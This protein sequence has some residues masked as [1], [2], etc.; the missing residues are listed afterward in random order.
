M[1][2]LKNIKHVTINTYYLL[3][4]MNSPL[5]LKIK[6]LLFIV[7]AINSINLTSAREQIKKRFIFNYAL[8]M[9]HT[10]QL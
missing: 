8:I 6:F 10:C 7:K 9:K 5:F 4:S 3:I 2:K 1:T